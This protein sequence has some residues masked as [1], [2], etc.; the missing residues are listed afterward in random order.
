MTPFIIFLAANV[1]AL[2]RFGMLACVATNVFTNAWTIHVLTVD[3]STW[4]VGQSLFA[5]L[6]LAGITVYGFWVSLAGRSLFSETM[7]E[8]QA[9]R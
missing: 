9:V 7:L 2:V 3:F 1:V 6:V 4:Y 5:L 8:V